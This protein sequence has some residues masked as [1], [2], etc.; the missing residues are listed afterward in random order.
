M[1]DQ[2]FTAI[3]PL[4]LLDIIIK[5]ILSGIRNLPSALLGIIT[6]KARI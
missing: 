1:H 4:I 2:Y 3:I 5:A 6:V